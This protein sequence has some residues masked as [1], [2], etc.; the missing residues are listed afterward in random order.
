M[1]VGVKSC[2]APT[3]SNLDGN[4]GEV[5][6]AQVNLRNQKKLFLGSFYRKPG[7]DTNQLE[8]LDSSL[9]TIDKLTRNSTNSL[10]VL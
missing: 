6:W 7:N 4:E 1:L 8:Y 9:T 10:T 5:V 2:Y 3:E